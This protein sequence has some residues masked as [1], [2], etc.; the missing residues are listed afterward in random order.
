MKSKK[1]LFK[2]EEE[3][4]RSKS[5]LLHDLQIYKRAQLQGKLKPEELFEMAILLFELNRKDLAIK[6]FEDE[7][8]KHPKSAKLKTLF[9]QFLISRK[10]YQEAIETANKF[11][12]EKT[13][14]LYMLTGVAYYYLNEYEFS[15]INFEAYLATGHGKYI[16]ESY[17]Y[18]ASCYFKLGK[19]QKAEK[20][21]EKSQP[22]LKNVAELFIL[23]AMIFH[24]RKM[25]YNAY[26][27]LLKAK[28]IEGENKLVRELKLKILMDMGENAKAEAYLKELLKKEERNSKNFSF[29]GMLNLKLSKLNEAKI[30]FEKALKINPNDTTAL[31]GIKILKE[32]LKEK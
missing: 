7:I 20:F 10:L 11:P 2:E 25:Y 23:K 13:P 3:K 5:R 27:A 32:T 18:I 26:E 1:K 21:L 15:L 8:E 30:Y 19:I 24:A 22:Y 16:G 31:E 17:F 4:P 14:A 12:K 9:L 29:L 28:L 6:S